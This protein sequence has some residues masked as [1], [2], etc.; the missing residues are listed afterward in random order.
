M[1]LGCVAVS[2]CLMS[3]SAFDQVAVVQRNV[4]LR[5]DPST[6]ADPITLLTPPARLALVEADKKNGY[7]HVRTADGQEGWVYSRNVSIV[8]G[9]AGPEA[10]AGP[11]PT[12]PS[13]RVGPPEIYPDPVKT[14]GVANPDITQANIADN[15][16]SL[17]WS[18]KLIRP[19]SSY[20]SPLKRSQMGPYGDTVSDADA[21]CVLHSDNSK[22]YEE[23]HLISLENGGDPKDPKN[24]WPEPYNT[25]ING[26][27]VGAR[28]KDQ[29]EGFIHD[30][31]CFDVPNHKRNSNIPAHISITLHRG[32]EILATDWY[33]CY[34]SIQKREG[35]R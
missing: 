9:P 32:Q 4:N 24:L 5:S 15:L 3:S 6:G 11:G 30:E 28:Q 13:G 21:S 1:R 14:P 8:E 35:C 16:C 10:A 34:Q 20:T 7:F 12:S 22:C 2:F 23:D 26:K 29:V 17:N 27:V 18:T 31:I 19:P 25:T 33:A